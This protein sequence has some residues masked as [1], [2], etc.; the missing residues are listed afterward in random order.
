MAEQRNVT[1]A[2]AAL[3]NKPGEIMN[4]PRLNVSILATLTTFALTSA[5]V[6]DNGDEVDIEPPDTPLNDA[7]AIRGMVFTNIKTTCI[8]RANWH[9]GTISV[10]PGAIEDTKA[11][12]LST[13]VRIPR[14]VWVD[15]LIL[16]ILGKTAS[17][18]KINYSLAVDAQPTLSGAPE[19]TGTF[20]V[21]HT[22]Q[23]TAQ[24][25]Q[26]CAS[27]TDHAIPIVAEIAIPENSI[28]SWDLIDLKFA[29]VQYCP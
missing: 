18:A 16:S 1:H 28:G 2:M 29:N 22:A 20:L 3:T 4:M 19:K 9:P 10:L 17:I 8:S 25:N 15:G 27:A 24:A 21:Q 14:G 5:C 7:D 11:C 13:T 12:K 6:D 26:W 23:L